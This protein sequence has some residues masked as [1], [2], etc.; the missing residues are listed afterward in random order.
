[1]GLDTSHDAWH[2]PYSSFNEFR[3]KLASKIGVNIKSLQGYGGDQPFPK[4]DLSILLDHS[5]CDGEISPT[6]CAKL[7]IR[8]EEI[9][10]DIPEEKLVFWS[11]HKQTTQ[12]IKGLKLA[13][14]KN[15]PLDFH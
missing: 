5:D 11:L 15:E 8:L 10:T 3:G 7:A 1:M 6:D 13:A 4:D 9:L 14:S 2:G 12:F